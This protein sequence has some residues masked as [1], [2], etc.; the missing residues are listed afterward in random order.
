MVRRPAQWP[1]MIHACG[2]STAMWSLMFFA[3]D[4]PTPMLTIVMPLL[5]PRRRWYAGIC[6]RR[7]G[8]LPAGPTGARE[9]GAHRDDVAGLDERVV[10]RV[11]LGH[12]AV[13]QRDELVDVELVVREQHEVLEVVGRGAGV[14]AQ[15]VQRVVDARRGEQRQRQRVGRA[16]LVGAVG[17]AVVHRGE[18]GQVEQVAQL[19]ALRRR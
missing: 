5:S 3:L 13:A 10:H 17:D 12:L 1:S 7:G 8:A 2:R 4:G 16:G 6:G 18:V 9:A 15:P 19:Q 11:G 14:V